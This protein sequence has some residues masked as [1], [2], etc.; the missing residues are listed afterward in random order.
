M[1]LFF[2]CVNFGSEERGATDEH[3]SRGR[4]APKLEEIA[5]SPISKSELLLN[6]VFLTFS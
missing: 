4:S 3:L 5:N 1:L 2:L 6:T